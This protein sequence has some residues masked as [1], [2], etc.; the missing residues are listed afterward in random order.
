MHQKGKPVFRGLTQ[1]SIF[2]SYDS[3]FNSTK[4]SSSMTDLPLNTIINADC[5]ETLASMPDE[6]VDV[7]FAD[8]P[9]NLQLQGDLWRPDNSRVDAVD[10]DW[11]QFN[12][13][14][15]FEQF[16][17]EWLR[18]CRRVLKKNGTIWVIGSYHNIYIV[19]YLMQKMGF[20]TLN[21]IIWNKNNPMPNFNGQRFCNAHETLIWAGKSQKSKVTFNYEAMK[22]G[23]E[24]KQMRSDWELPICNGGER[25][26]NSDGSKV[27]STQKPEAL[28][29][30]VLLASTQP[31]DIVLDPFFG[32]GTTGAV[33][34]KMA[35]HFI[36]IEG[37]EAYANAAQQRIDAVQAVD[38][39]DPNFRIKAKRKEKRIPF[40]DL[41]Q[42]ELLPVGATLV[43][44]KSNI[45]AIVDSAG[46]LSAIVEGR[47]V[48]GSIHKVAATIEGQKS[49]NGWD[50]WY[51]VEANGK[52]KMVSI[53]TLR[54]TLR[55]RL[56]G[57]GN[58]G[59]AAPVMRGR[60]A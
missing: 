33:A 46:V 13:F 51:V 29:Y 32:S 17:R 48:V 60:A 28:L 14:D 12:S 7:I 9:Y 18:Q 20:W 24:D 3:H 40:G 45:R 4:V 50:Y 6:C 49:Y 10:Q 39:N 53:D 56:Y 15:A 52:G 16:N 36:G 34:K 57:A 25:L 47:Q 38:M 37:D 11:D 23:N 1:D 41:L 8:P 22:T 35:R 31:G 5:I 58:G 26:K 59:E 30:R 55:A 44:P 42:Y 2:D 43:S 21:D 27:H 54:N 19:G